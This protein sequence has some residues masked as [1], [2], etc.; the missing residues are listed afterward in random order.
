M[1]ENTCLFGELSISFMLL[2]SK[3]D[4]YPTYMLDDGIVD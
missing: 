4:S 3:S 2:S 1:D